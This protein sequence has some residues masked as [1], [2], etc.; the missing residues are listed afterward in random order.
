MEIELSNG[1]WYA[2]LNEP[3]GGS[4][5]NCAFM[6]EPELCIEACAKFDCRDNKVIFTEVYTP[7]E[8]P[9]VGEEEEPTEQSKS[10]LDVQI[11]GSHYKTLKIQP[12]EFIHANN[13]PFIEGN[14]IKYICR[15]RSKNGIKDLEKVKHYVDLLIELEKLK[16]Q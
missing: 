10:A 6:D 12:I 13:I 1:K 8:P 2:T 5:A 16:G 11:S 14:V 3:T 7:E 4:C 15:W 9:E